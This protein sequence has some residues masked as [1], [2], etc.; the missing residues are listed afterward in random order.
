M[1][2]VATAALGLAVE[3]TPEPARAQSLVAPY[4]STNAAT[5]AALASDQPQVK[6]IDLEEGETKTRPALVSFPRLGFGGSTDW[7]EPL[8]API[9]R[10]YDSYLES[11][12][13]ISDQY[14]FDFSVD[15]TLYP[16]FGTKGNPV[17]LAVYYPSAT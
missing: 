12:K 1:S 15:F 3:H 14:H 9:D 11:K 4:A 7:A 8:G 17:W 13:I 5:A 10:F 6:D 2:V 16:Q